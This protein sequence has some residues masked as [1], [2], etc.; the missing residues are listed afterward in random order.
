M[1]IHGLRKI[2]L[3]VL[4]ITSDHHMIDFMFEVH[5]PNTRTQQKHVPDYNWASFGPRTV[6]LKLGSIDHH[7]PEFGQIILNDY[8]PYSGP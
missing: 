6:T 7:G 8:G 2:G 1:T 4:D 3:K 5:D